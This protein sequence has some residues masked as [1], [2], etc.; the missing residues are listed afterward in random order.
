MTFI[1]RK[2]RKSTKAWTWTPSILATQAAS[3]VDVFNTLK[4]PSTLNFVAQPDITLTFHT[5]PTLS[6]HLH[7]ALLADVSTLRQQYDASQ[8]PW[9]PNSKAAELRHP[10]HRLILASHPSIPNRPAAFIAF[11]WDVEDDHPIMYVYELF[12]TPSLRGR[13]VASALMR[14]AEALCISLGIFRILLTVFDTNIPALKL[15]RRTLG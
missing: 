12:V 1:T 5:G 9:D 8:M 6:A 7:S 10:D 15:Y 4:L 11:R 13:R 2:R 3:V 14:F